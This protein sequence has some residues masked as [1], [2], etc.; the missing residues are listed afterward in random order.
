MEQKF[1]V[2]EHC[3][4]IAA[5]VKESGV[6][7]MCCGEKMKELIPGVTEAAAEKHIPVCVVKNNQVTVTV[8]E[9]SH[10]MLPEHYIEWISLETKQGNQRKVLKPGDKPQASFAICEGDEVVAAYAYCNLHSL[11]KK[12]VEEK[13]QEE[14]MPD[15]DYI[16]CKCNHVSYYD[17]IDEVHKHS[18][19]EELLRVFED[20]R[21]TT[22]CST[23][24]GGC[25]DKVMDIISR[26]IMG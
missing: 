8:G 20:V 12:E 26:T 24:C 1:Y 2:C 13:K 3:G 4:K 22:R 10:P 16:V 15:G 23:G 7:L 19:M 9:V 11:W 18:N 25:Y 17:I 6:P 14:K 21:D 5:I